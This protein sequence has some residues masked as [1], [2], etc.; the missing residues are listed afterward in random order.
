MTGIKEQHAFEAYL[1]I[2]ITLQRLW[3]RIIKKKPWEVTSFL[4]IPPSTHLSSG[5]VTIWPHMCVIE[6]I[7][8]K[9]MHSGWYKVK[10]IIFP[11]TCLL[12]AQYVVS[13]LWHQRHIP[14]NFFTGFFCT[15]QC[16]T[17]GHKLLY[18]H[19]VELRRNGALFSFCSINLVGFG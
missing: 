12:G 10:I 5:V 1:L 2:Y 8:Q 3:G 7:L 14:H 9:R 19:T 18:G 6:L 11:H 4:K 17:C 16:P 15:R 13:S